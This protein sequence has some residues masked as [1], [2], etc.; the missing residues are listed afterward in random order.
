MQLCHLPPRTADSLSTGMNRLPA[1]SAIRV[2]PTIYHSAR[3]SRDMPLLSSAPREVCN[4]CRAVLRGPT[5]PAPAIAT[6]QEKT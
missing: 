2:T 4:A 5:L 3:R 6:S 1:F